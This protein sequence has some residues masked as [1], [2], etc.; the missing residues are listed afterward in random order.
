MAMRLAGQPVWGI[1]GGRLFPTALLDVVALLVGAAACALLAVLAAFSPRAASVVVGVARPLGMAVPAVVLGPLL[2]LVLAIQLRLFP[3]FGYVPL[4]PNVVEGIRHLILPALTLG[5]GAAAFALGQVRSG[6]LAPPRRGGSWAAVGVHLLGAVLAGTFV[7]EPIFGWPGIG[8][9]AFEGILR[10]DYGVFWAVALLVALLYLVIAAPVSLGANFLALR[11]TG[12]SSPP[13]S[14]GAARVE[15]RAPRWVGITLLGV[16][17]A[18]LVVLALAALVVPLLHDPLRLDLTAVES[19]PSAAHPLGAD[20]LGRD[21]LGRALAAARISLGVGALS[22][23]VAAVIGVGLGALLGLIPR[24]A[25]G[26]SALVDGGI[27]TLV[28]FPAVALGLA[29][30]VVLRPSFFS[31]VAAFAIAQIPAFVRPAM[32]LMRTLIGGPAGGAQGAT[33]RPVAGAVGAVLGQLPISVALVILG[34]SALSFLG[35]GLRP[36]TPEWGSMIGDGLSE[37]LVTPWPLLGP[38]LALGVAVFGLTLLG[39]ALRLACV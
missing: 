1:I 21:I 28:A 19:P 35:M 34:E 22:A 24:A 26:I 13:P 16:A 3:A 11:M 36:P 30:V 33:A 5:L 31:L 14:R 17:G 39:Q 2:I 20:A 12:T 18:L 32:A 15:R 9:L 10:R 8:L 7:V 4:L 27:S 6:A 37:L 23:I 29:V 25:R 38:A